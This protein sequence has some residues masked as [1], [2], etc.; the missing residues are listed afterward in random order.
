MRGEITENKM[1]ETCSMHGR[2]K[3]SY[4]TVIGHPK[5]RDHLADIDADRRKMLK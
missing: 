4:E 2:H 5:E 1:G 3:Y